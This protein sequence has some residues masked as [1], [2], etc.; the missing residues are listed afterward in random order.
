[1]SARGH[2]PD[3]VNWPDVTPPIAEHELIGDL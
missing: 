2:H 1:M 3:R